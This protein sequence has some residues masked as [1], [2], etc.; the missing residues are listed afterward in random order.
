M[1]SAP[2]DDEAARL[3]GSALGLV[4]RVL[5]KPYLRSDARHGDAVPTDDQHQKEST[6]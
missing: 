4:D 6:G 3:E 5:A 2:P 1:T